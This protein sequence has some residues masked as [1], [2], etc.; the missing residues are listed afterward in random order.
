[1]T[2]TRGREFKLQYATS[3]H[4]TA[5]EDW[6]SAGM[7]YDRRWT[8]SYT[9]STRLDKVTLPGTAK[10]YQFT[11]TTGDLLTDVCAPRELAGGTEPPFTYLHMVYSSGRV[12][13]Q[14]FGTAGQ[15]YTFSYDDV[16][17]AFTEIDREGT[18]RRYA[19]D[20]ST[21]AIT[22]ITVEMGATDPT[23]SYEWEAST[24]L[25]TKIVFPEGNGIRYV[26]DEGRVTT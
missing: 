18:E 5:L 26:Y 1:I 9:G 3:G 10:A 7:T 6:S 22:S 25:L 13:T 19:F 15:E 8:F 24:A 17:H 4:L 20:G 21:G 12:V 23:T 2:D 16:N 14:R 11:Y